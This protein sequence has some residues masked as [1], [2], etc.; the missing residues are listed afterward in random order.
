MVKKNREGSSSVGKLQP[1]YIGHRQRLKERYLTCGIGGF[2][3]YEKLELI[4]SYAIPRKDMKPIAKAL[5]SRFGSIRGVF[6]ADYEELQ[7]VDGI[8]EHAALLL[9]LIKDMLTTYLKERLLDRVRISCTQDLVNYWRTE[10]GSLKDER[11]YVMYLNSQ[12]HLIAIEQIQ[13]GT[14]NQAIVPPR[15]VLEKALWHKASAMILIHNHP[16]GNVRPSEHDIQLTRT[17][18]KTASAL[19][20]A[21]HDHVIIGADGFFSLREEGL[22]F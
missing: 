7:K 5:I 2:Q 1:H 14:V 15:K 6:D 10:I 22:L 20:I 8:G 9:K 3:D 11:F 21:V 17:I 13:E 12:N 18:Q 19:N 16:S 4:L